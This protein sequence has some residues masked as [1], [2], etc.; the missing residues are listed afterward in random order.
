MSHGCKFMLTGL[1][2]EINDKFHR[3]RMLGLHLATTTNI[4]IPYIAFCVLV[5]TMPVCMG[6]CVFV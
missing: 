3:H 6:V 1:A 2:K 5:F 4:H